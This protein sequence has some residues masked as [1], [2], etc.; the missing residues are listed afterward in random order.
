MLGKLNNNRQRVT[1]LDLGKCPLLPGEQG[2][3][4]VM[5]LRLSPT[6]PS[7]LLWAFV[8]CMEGTPLACQRQLSTALGFLISFRWQSS[9]SNK[10]V[11]P[12][13]YNS[14]SSICVFL[15]LTNL[16]FSLSPLLT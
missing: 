2:Q 9:Q 10:I 16:L 5:G 11:K 7:L 8:M 14:R 15:R 1:E 13:S 4:C 6:T 3:W 12:L